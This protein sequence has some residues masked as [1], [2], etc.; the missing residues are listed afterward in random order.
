MKHWADEL[1]ILH[2]DEPHEVLVDVTDY[3]S[4]DDAQAEVTRSNRERWADLADTAT[5]YAISEGASTLPL[6]A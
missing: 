2:A 3:A 6:V 4:S 5:Y 1:Y